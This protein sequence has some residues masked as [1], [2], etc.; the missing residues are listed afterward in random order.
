[1][2][3]GHRR[4]LSGSRFSFAQVFSLAPVDQ[5]QTPSANER[6]LMGSNCPRRVVY[7]GLPFPKGCAWLVPACAAA[8][9]GTHGKP[10]QDFPDIRRA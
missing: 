4:Q 1:M 8:L 7:S 5:N 10:E 3:R 2:G 6:P 9:R